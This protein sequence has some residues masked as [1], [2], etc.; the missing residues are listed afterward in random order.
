MNIEE[1]LQIVKD[2]IP[3]GY[4]VVVK[5]S[6]NKIAVDLETPND[7]QSV[8]TDGNI[9]DQILSA[10]DQAIDDAESFNDEI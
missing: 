6:K 10:L 7:F 8:P 2:K 9:V 4:D 5:V 3:E 1:S